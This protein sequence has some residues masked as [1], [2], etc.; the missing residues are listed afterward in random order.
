MKSQLVGP[1]EFRGMNLTEDEFEFLL[2]KT[3]AIQTSIKDDPRL[4][5]SR[6]H[7]LGF[8]KT[9]L[10]KKPYQN[11]PVCKDLG[12]CTGTGNRGT[13]TLTRESQ[14]RHQW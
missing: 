13:C 7:N 4:V 10:W 1:L 6:N 8:R 3:G 5:M 2:G 11:I 14:T 12:T 9:V